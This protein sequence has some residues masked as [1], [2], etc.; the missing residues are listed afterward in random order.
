[1]QA[2]DFS[3]PT[4]EEDELSLSD[5]EGDYVILN[6]WA[7]W[8]PPCRE[9]MPDFAAFYEDYQDEGVHV[10]GLNRTATEPGIDAVR[11]F[12][13]DFSLP[14]PV[15]IDEEDVVEDRYN[16]Y[17]M[18]TTYIITPDG[19][20]AMNRPGYISYDVLEEQYLTIREQYEEEA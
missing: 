2:P 9:E 12:A 14:F 3:L 1:M 4:L 11:Q 18:P 17:V 15:V 16:V 8:C 6:I 5:F 7:T 10:L 13:D 20:V 19:R